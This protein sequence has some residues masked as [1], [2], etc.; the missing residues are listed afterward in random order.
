MLALPLEPVN[1]NESIAIL[2]NNASVDHVPNISFLP[3]N[4]LKISLFKMNYEIILFLS[5]A[6]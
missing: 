5:Q 6:I 4:L 2:H 1:A 3:Y